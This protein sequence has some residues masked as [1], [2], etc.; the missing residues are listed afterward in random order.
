MRDA[1]EQV[2]A[3][4]W[5]SKCMIAGTKCRYYLGDERPAPKY[6]LSARGHLMR[7]V[8]ANG[9]LAWRYADYGQGQGEAVSLAEVKDM[10]DCGKLNRCETYKTANFEVEGFGEDCGLWILWR[11]PRYWGNRSH[12]Q[13]LA[14][15]HKIIVKLRDEE[16]KQRDLARAARDPKTPP[17]TMHTRTDTM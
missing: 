14:P 17:R 8:L 11:G 16:V 12:V 5:L 1:S 3:P 7:H 2:E 4:D 6:E 9:Y 15:C 13:V 10:I